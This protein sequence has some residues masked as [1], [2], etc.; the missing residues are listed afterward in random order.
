[1]SAM[2][3]SA[4]QFAKPRQAPPDLEFRCPDCPICDKE[5]DTD[6]DSFV[7]Y[8][9]DAHWSMDGR[10]GAWF[11]AEQ[12]ACPS[13]IKPF[14]RPDLE[15]KY[16]DIRHAIEACVY[17]DGHAGK[18]KSIDTYWGWDDGDPRCVR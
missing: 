15:P 1:M 14:D 10:K 16:E 8:T 3:N 6:G 11:E 7:C 18:H 12:I 13:K 4:G 2:R 5:L 17:E 9:C